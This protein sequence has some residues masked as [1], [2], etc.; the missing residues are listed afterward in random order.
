MFTLPLSFE[1]L[2]SVV[3]FMEKLS[4]TNCRPE[5]VEFVEKNVDT[6]LNVQVQ[7]DTMA[8]LRESFQRGEGGIDVKEPDNDLV[9]A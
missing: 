9:E 5:T 2:K 1:G 3:Q 6:R 8:G 7:D 4:E